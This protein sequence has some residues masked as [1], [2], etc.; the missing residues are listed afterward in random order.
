M[1]LWMAC[2]A[3]QGAEPR[4]IKVLPAEGS[5]GINRAIAELKED[6]GEIVLSAGTYHILTPL[7]LRHSRTTLRGAGARS[8]LLRLKPEANCPVIIIGDEANTPRYQVS[9][10]CVADLGVD[11]NKAQQEGECWNG[12]CDTGELTALRSSGIVIRGARNILVLRT[13]VVDC[14]SGGLV[15]EKHCRKLVVQDFTA[16][17]HEFDGLACYETEG[18][19]FTNLYLHDNKSAGISTDLEFDHNTLRHVRMERNGSHG[20]F[21]RNSSHNVF[22]NIESRGSGKAGIFIDQVDLLARTAS[23]GNRFTDVTVT[24]A[25]GPAVQVNAASCK[26]N[27]LSRT[28]FSGNKEGLREAEPGLVKTEGVSAR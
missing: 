10:V 2:I 1:V 15:T 8:T 20:I 7:I 26:R 27:S 18:S 12:K 21:M 17:E 28:R 24:G 19:L 25:K 16:S 13:R 11:G 3:V 23:V 5:G 6:G 22:E 9:G 14:R 4:V